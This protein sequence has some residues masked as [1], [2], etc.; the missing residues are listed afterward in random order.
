MPPGGKERNMSEYAGYMGRVAKLDLTTQ[1][2]TDYPWSDRERE[3]YM[4][5][6]IMAAKILYDN[7]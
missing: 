5:G 6:K 3:L 7:L 1:T 2:V 4:G